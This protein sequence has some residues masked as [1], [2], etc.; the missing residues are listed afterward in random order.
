MKRPIIALALF[1]LNTAFKLLARP[2]TNPINPFP[3]S[4]LRAQARICG[5]FGTKLRI[6]LNAPDNA[7]FNKYPKCARI[8]PINPCLGS[9][10]AF[11]SCCSAKLIASSNRCF[12]ISLF[13]F[14]F[15][16][17]QPQSSARKKSYGNY[18]SHIVDKMQ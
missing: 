5:E 12:I 17:E 9:S 16:F 1:S 15:S 13:S 10:L 7:I 4:P 14:L 6:P 18:K 2:P 3:E 8:E 11:R